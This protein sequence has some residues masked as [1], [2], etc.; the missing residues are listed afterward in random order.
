M[1]EC[2]IQVADFGTM[3][4]ILYPDR[5]PLT[6]ASFAYSANAGFYD[7]LGFCRIVKDYV[8]QGGSPDNDIM[9]DSDF[10]LTG[11][12]RENGFDTGLLHRR[13][14]ISMARDDGFDTAGTQF[15]ICHRDAPRLDGRYAAFGDICDGL[16][17]LDSIA[18]VETGGSEVWNRPLRMPV[19]TRVRVLSGE[20]LPR[21]IRLP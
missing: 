16:D 17:V 11:E 6:V 9:T 21:V 14:T 4:F 1:T 3:R 15:F 12:F 7:G 13:G 10:H 18:Q 19:M 8:I 2:T 5:A 20:K